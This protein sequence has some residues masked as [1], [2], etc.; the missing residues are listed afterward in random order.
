MAS[1]RLR[2]IVL[3]G[4]AATSQLHDVEV[5]RESIVFELM[6][7]IHRDHKLTWRR[8]RILCNGQPVDE[9]DR[10]SQLTQEDTIEVQLLHIDHRHVKPI[11]DRVKM[12]TMVRCSAEA[13]GCASEELKDDKELVRIAVASFGKALEFAS[14]AL[15]RDP[16]LA[17]LAMAT[18][19]WIFVVLGKTLRN[20]P[21][22][23]KRAID[24]DPDLMRFCH[25]DLFKDAEFMEH[26]VQR[27][28]S[29]LRFRKT[30][31]KKEVYLQAL[32]QD[33]LC[34]EFLQET[35]RQNGMALAFACEKLRHDVQIVSEALRNN[36]RAIKFVSSKGVICQLV[37]ERPS[38]LKHAAW[39]FRDDVEVVNIAYAS[40]TTCLIYAGTEAALEML[41]IHG[42][43]VLKLLKPSIHQDERVLQ[44][45]QELQASSLPTIV[46][47]VVSMLRF[48]LKFP[49]VASLIVHTYFAIGG[50]LLFNWVFQEVLDARR[51]APARDMIDSIFERVVVH[52]QKH[53]LN[54]L[55]QAIDVPTLLLCGTREVFAQ[56]TDKAVTKKLLDPFT[57]AIL[58]NALSKVGVTTCRTGAV[59]RL[60]LSCNAAELK[61][62]KSALDSTG[63]YFNLHKLIYSDL[64]EPVRSELLAHLQERSL[65]LRADGQA[66]GVKILSDIDDTVLCSGGVFPAGCDKRLPKK[67][68]YPGFAT[69]LRELD[70]SFTP[71]EPCSNVVFLSARP[72]IY[73]DISEQ[74]TFRTV[75]QLFH[76]AVLHTIP[77]LLSGS[78][79]IGFGAVVKRC[80]CHSDAWE[81]VG[82]Y[83]HTVF[84]QYARLYREYDFIFFGDNGQGDLLAGQLM[85]Q[86]PEE[87]R[88][89]LDLEKSL[90]LNSQE[91]F[92][93]ELFAEGILLHRTYVGAALALHR[94]FPKLISV[95]QLRSVAKC[96]QDDFDTSRIMYP[97]WIRKWEAY[98]E[99]L[100][101]DLRAASPLL[102][103]AGLPLLRCLQCTNTLIQ[104]DE[105]FVRIFQLA[106]TYSESSSD[107]ESQHNNCCHHITYEDEAIDL[108]DRLWH[109]IAPESD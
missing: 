81:E 9:C 73:K 18:H 70:S 20:D 106:N 22:Q 37:Q 85:M 79:R 94:S 69:L 86:G 88:P 67:M 33:G 41:K 91:P 49:Q 96:A 29:L 55:L 93:A 15:K 26:C 46:L 99:E 76:Q 40:D 43:E 44:L 68:V 72:H 11:S 27:C 84:Q 45:V 57:K 64:R 28:A 78:L 23:A 66:V 38:A 6:L 65:E 32:Q 34:L 71:S 83:K 51:H 13:L 92:P 48:C 75:Q 108:Q 4:L 8:Q 90:T 97:E 74:K 52:E 42:L 1:N 5:D 39:T 61:E 12:M 17:D 103:S 35:L 109:L 80:F 107:E 82:R 53:L 98:E 47:A 58:L 16:D 60:I 102:A 89:V 7:I 105:P 21:E 19:P 100:S 87:E 104:E 2:I 50:V 36:E 25:Q 101:L 3:K 59:R 54:E 24:A 63:D 56:L 10:W 62:L 14:K 30:V 77:S 31:L 95:Q